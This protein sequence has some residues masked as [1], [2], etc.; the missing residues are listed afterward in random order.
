M[1]EGVRVLSLQ[2]PHLGYPQKMKQLLV[3]H[4][5]PSERVSSPPICPL[6]CVIISTAISA[7]LETGGTIAS[8]ETGRKKKVGH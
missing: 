3:P 5:S 4:R 8:P 1:E 6:C 7:P 2:P